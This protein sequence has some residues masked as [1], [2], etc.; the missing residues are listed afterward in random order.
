MKK[1]LLAAL[2]AVVLLAVGYIALP[3]YTLDRLE[4]AAET[5]NVEQLQRYIDFPALRDNLKVRL[6]R[7][8][9]ESAGDDIP[10]EFGDLLV[11]GA[12]LFIGPLL[13]HLVTPEGIGELLQGG[14]NLRAF[15][16]ELYRQS[17]P[18]V[19]PPP[20][21][22]EDGG[23][24]WHRQRWRF[25]G[26]NRVTADYGEDGETQLRLLLER[27]GMRWRLVDIELLAINNER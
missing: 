11:A 23:A 13:Q 7:Q 19:E 25:T 3:E 4:Q 21:M 10:P 14:R 12:N 1:W 27:Q 26:F 17:S 24:G 9:R 6:Q 22:E 5:E 15:E 2:V 8:L 16:R 18:S 20:E